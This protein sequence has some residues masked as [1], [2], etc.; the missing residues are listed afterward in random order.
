ME[1]AAARIGATDIPEAAELARE[2]LQP[3]AAAEA[4]AHFEEMRL[5]R[6]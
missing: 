2:T 5:G 1:A 4:T 3:A 6:E